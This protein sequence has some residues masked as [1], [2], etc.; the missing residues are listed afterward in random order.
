MVVNT[1]PRFFKFKRNKL[2]VLVNTIS[3]F[4]FRRNKTAH[5]LT[6]TVLNGVVCYLTQFPRDFNYYIP[7]IVDILS[8]GTVV[9]RIQSFDQRALVRFPYFVNFFRL[10]VSTPFYMFFTF[11]QYGSQATVETVPWRVS[12]RQRAQ[13][14]K[15]APEST[16]S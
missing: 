13:F 16:V 6:N 8:L 12:L 7:K 9:V 2:G 14:Q 1:I 5:T 15:A 11:M 3:R 10:W 4:K